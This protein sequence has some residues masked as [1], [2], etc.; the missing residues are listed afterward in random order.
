MKSYRGL[1]TQIEGFCSRHL[2]VKKYLGEFREQMPNFATINEKYPII[3]VAPSSNSTEL[4]TNQFTLDIYC[5]DVIQ[6]DRANINTI[7]SDTNLILNDL[8]LYFKDGEDLG[9]D[10]IGTPTMSPLNN[11]DLD[12]V[13]GWLMTITFEVNQFS[14]CEIPMTPFTP[15]PNVC[16]P[17]TV[18]N[19]D[20]SY[21]QIVQS[22]SS[23]TLPNTTYNINVN[24]V[25]NQTVNL[26]TLKDEVININA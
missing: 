15:V 21:L 7:L 11:F 10:V 24:G 4:D 14:V 19:A 12:Y 2:Q 25:F 3:F 20:S 8:Q 26:I 18:K 16:D 22:G 6:K 23:L 9:I 5:V 1:L 13:A 17:V